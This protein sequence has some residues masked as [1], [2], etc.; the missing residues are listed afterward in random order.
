MTDF[1]RQILR[2]LAGASS[3]ALAWGAAVGAAIEWLHGNGYVT[4]RMAGGAIRYEISEKGKA[5]I[6]AETLK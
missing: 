1:E 5:I 2:H 3:P 4:R 6:A